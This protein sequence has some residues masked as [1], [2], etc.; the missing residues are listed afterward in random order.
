MSWN[1]GTLTSWN[2]LSHSSPVTGLLYPLFS[3]GY[4]FKSHFIQGERQVGYRLEWKSQWM[5]CIRLQSELE[6]TSAGKWQRSAIPSNVCY[7]WYSCHFQQR[8]A[9]F[10][11]RCTGVVGV[12]TYFKIGRN[13]TLNLSLLNRCLYLGICDIRDVLWIIRKCASTPPPR[14]RLPTKNR[15][16]INV[17]RIS[18][19]VGKS[20]AWVTYLLLP[21]YS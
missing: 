9:P 20:E 4:Q 14:K 17:R 6:M 13:S 8:E 11:H 1:L 5:Y 16:L 3:L 15:K 2:P 12:A 18:K 7:V 19:K 21:M 10:C